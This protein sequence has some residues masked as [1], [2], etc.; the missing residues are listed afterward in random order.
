MKSLKFLT[1]FLLPLCVYFSFTMNGWITFLPLLF[2]FAIIPLLEFLFEPTSDNFSKEQE[3]KEKENKIYTYILYLTILIQLYFL[4]L[5]F[6]AVQEP[7][8]ETYELAG[9][10]IGM[11]LLSGTIG[12]NVGHELGH[13]NNRFDEFLGEILLLSSINT[14]FLPYHNAGH[15]LNVATPKDAATA[16]K[17]EIIYFFWIRSHFSMYLQ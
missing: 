2:S 9:R 10:I 14:H 15:H 5:F 17:N 7:N 16:R 1:V 11:G 12:I 4:Y 8:L 6:Y 13:R 3:Q